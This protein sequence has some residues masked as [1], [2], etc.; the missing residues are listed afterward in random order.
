M[1]SRPRSRPQRS[2]RPQPQRPLIS[3]YAALRR[4]RHRST[5]F[6]SQVTL[7]QDHFFW[8]RL[9]SWRL[10]IAAWV[11]EWDCRLGESTDWSARRHSLTNWHWRSL[12]LRS[13]VAPRVGC[14]ARA[15]T[16]TTAWSTTSAGTTADE[17]T[18]RAAQEMAGSE[19]GGV[20]GDQ[21]RVAKRR[22]T[23][24]ARSSAWPGRG[25]CRGVGGHG[26]RRQVK[27][28][29]GRRR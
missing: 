3:S 8:Q 29:M 28:G 11:R 20:A 2:L 6:P 23:A 15:I 17:V 19:P 10:A 26:H 4:S 13:D 1:A 12:A 16:A 18:R 22:V 21:M 27:D 25:G 9:A 24:A 14:C 5:H 7:R